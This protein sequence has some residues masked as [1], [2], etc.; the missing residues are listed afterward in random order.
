MLGFR[1]N[2]KNVGSQ[3]DEFLLSSI[4]RAKAQWDQA[5]ETESAISE[6]D[7]EIVAQTQLSKA[8]YLF[9]YREARERNVSN[10]RIQSSVIDY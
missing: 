10:N 6:V 8:K 3:Y 4:D 2:I 5:K 7:E 9:L 1:K